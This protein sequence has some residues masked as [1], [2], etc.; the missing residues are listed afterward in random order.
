MLRIGALLRTAPPPQ[1]SPNLSG[2][3]ALVGLDGNFGAYLSSLNVPEFLH[4]LIANAG[5]TMEVLE[6]KD[7]DGLWRIR[8]VAGELPATQP[9]C[10]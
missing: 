8:R 1:W 7:S 10:V 3:Y 9:L 2:T 6:P 4:E 5:E